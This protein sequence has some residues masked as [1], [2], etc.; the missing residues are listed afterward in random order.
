MQITRTEA[1]D[2]TIATVV[3]SCAQMGALDLGRY[4]HAYCDVHGLGKELPVKN[5]LMPV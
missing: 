5:A 3:S 1:Y 2:G 4:F